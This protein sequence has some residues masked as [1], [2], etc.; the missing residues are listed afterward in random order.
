MLNKYKYKLKFRTKLWITF[1]IQKSI[2]I[3]KKLLRKFINKNNPQIK[4]E[5][6]EKCKTYRNLLSTLTKD[7][8][9]IYYTKYFESNWNNIE[10]T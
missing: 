7:I 8:K 6:H 5:F 3:K 2:S 4:A 1:G 9:Q 10:N